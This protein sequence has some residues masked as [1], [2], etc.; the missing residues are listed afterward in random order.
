METKQVDLLTSVSVSIL[1]IT[2][3]KKHRKSYYNSECGRKALAE[4]E[5]QDVV[6][7]VMSIWGDEPT[8]ESPQASDL[9]QE[10]TT[11]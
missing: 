7:I 1:T 4:N 8:V 11:D 10:P 2:D 6:D 3:G 5:P 9:P